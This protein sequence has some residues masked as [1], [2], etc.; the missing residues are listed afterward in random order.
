M[1]INV[2]FNP[3]ELTYYTGC[4]SDIPRA[5]TLTNNSNQPIRVTVPGHDDRQ[6]S[7]NSQ[8]EILNH[9]Q[10]LEIMVYPKVEPVQPAGGEERAKMVINMQAVNTPEHEVKEIIMRRIEAV[11]GSSIAVRIT[12]NPQG[13]DVEAPL[14]EYVE[15]VNISN[16]ALNLNGV[17]IN[18][19]IFPRQIQKNLVTLAGIPSFPPGKTLRIFT[20]AKN[21]QVN[22]IDPPDDFIGSLWFYYCGSKAAVW[23]N[24]D[25][26][27]AFVLNQCKKV[28]V[29]QPYISLPAPS[30]FK[31]AS[32]ARTWRVD[33]RIWTKVLEGLQEGDLIR[34][35]ESKGAIAWYYDSSRTREP[36]GKEIPGG[37]TK[38]APDGFQWNDFWVRYFPMPGANEGSLLGYLCKPTQAPDE[39]HDY[40]LSE[41]GLLTDIG[42][43]NTDILVPESLNIF[44]DAASNL[45][46]FDFYLGI[47]DD[48]LYD[49]SG[50]FSCTV[51]HLR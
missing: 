20:R 4:G 25:D 19:L 38:T 27:K 32:P 3:G 46:P 11:D 36:D 45:G 12:P 17:Q 37:Q 49:N 21:S 47:N 44:T 26:D 30:G 14:G 31:P 9:L 43:R 28:I 51:E 42:L 16:I 5:I 50:A 23:N 39:R 33:A 35:T 7:W 2:S 1:A 10:T 34:I 8:N 29:E 13:N 48:V 18:H 6:F 22:P 41:H 40:P 24:S 15:I